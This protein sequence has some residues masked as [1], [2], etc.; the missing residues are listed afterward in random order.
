MCSLLSLMSYNIGCFLG[1]G[2]QYLDCQQQLLFVF[3][4]K[5]SNKTYFLLTIL[6]T[7]NM[8]F[9]LAKLPTQYV[10]F[11]GKCKIA[12]MFLPQQN[13]GNYRFFFAERHGM[14]QNFIDV[15]NGINS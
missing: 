8:C 3:V 2:S 15:F 7:Q 1:G 6:P 14:L 4:C 13:F 11:V 5:L 12:D 10:C 9:L